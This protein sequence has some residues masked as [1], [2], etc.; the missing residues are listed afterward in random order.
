MPAHC[1]RP[2]G[3]R[4]REGDVVAAR[5]RVV[6]RAASGGMGTVYEAL[7]TTAGVTVALKTLRVDPRG[8]RTRGES[9]LLPGAQALA[10][11]HHP[12]LRRHLYHVVPPGFR[13][14]PS[15]SWPA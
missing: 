2:D 11:G 14:F 7:D 1:R 9:R 6:R 10:E 3:V 5:Y 15:I 13:P 12:A 8:E 4:M